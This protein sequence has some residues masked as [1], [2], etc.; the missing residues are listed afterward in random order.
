M[1]VLLIIDCYLPSI[2]SVAQ[3]TYDLAMEFAAQNHDVTI[4][5]PSDALEKGVDISNEN[6]LQ[7]VRYRTGKIKG[8]R[9]VF[10]AINE[11]LIS[12]VAFWRM[13]KYFADHEYDCIV[14][15]SPSI[16]FGPLVVYLKRRWSIKSYLI[17]RDIFPDWAVHTG[18]LK[19][20]PAYYLFKV[21]EHIQYR[22]ADVIGVE[23]SR[24]FDYFKSTPF[25][26]KIELLRNW[27]VSDRPARLD[28]SY[29]TK[30]A[31]ED[32]VVFF[33]GGN[34]GV[35][36]DMDNIMRLAKRMAGQSN[37]H[38]VIVGEGSERERFTKM[39]HDENMGN[40]TILPSVDPD[41]YMS[42][43]SEFDVGLITLDRRLKTYSNTGKILGYMRCGLPILASHNPGN[44]LEDLLRDSQAGFGSINGEDDLLYENALKLCDPVLRR[45]MGANSR[46]L[47]EKTFSVKKTVT[48]ILDSLADRACAGIR[49]Y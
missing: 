21:F 18:V 24:S 32:K 49:G 2:K 36:Q 19:K 31:L 22:A 35:A 15:Y 42:M 41:T 28:H 13:R 8:A 20:G 5:A 12:L 6:G 33:Y 7:I 10:R 3:L 30:L 17:L 27:T 1:R 40:V 11:I 16:F 29:R 25:I 4:L 48:Q 9:L 44:D 38:F 43:L 14:F 23:T 26:D 47:L 39:A 46:R 45:K 37:A 34:I